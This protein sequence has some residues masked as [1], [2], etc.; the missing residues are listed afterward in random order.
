MSI[1]EVKLASIPG[2]EG[3]AP[4]QPAAAAPVA[5]PQQDVAPAVD[6][7]DGPPPPPAENGGAPAGGLTLKEDP[8]YATYFRMIRLGV[9]LPQIQ[10]KM[11]MEGVD[12]NILE[13][14]D[15]PSDYQESAKANSNKESDDDESDSD[16]GGEW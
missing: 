9:A 4:L 3:D 10:Q 16:D 2:L 14:P 1:L 12:P 5:Q 15:A 8:R 7:E 6:N 13:T 11:M